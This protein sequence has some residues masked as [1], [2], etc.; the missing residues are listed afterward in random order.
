VNTASETRALHELA[1]MYGVQT[2]YYDMTRTRRWTS[3]EALLVVLRSMGAPVETLRDVPSA[4]RQRQQAQ[5][6]QPLEP[7][8][9][10]W[11]SRAHSIEVR[12]PAAADASFAAHLTL[13]TGEQQSLTWRG[14]DLPVMGA[15]EVE[16]TRYVIKR[17]TLPGRLP[18]GYHRLTLDAPR[19]T[20][21]NPVESLIMVA[22]RRA[23]SFLEGSNGAAW[24]V[25]LPLY[26]LYTQRSWGS[27]ALSDLETLA[28]WVSQ[29]GGSVMATL[30]LLATFPEEPS[31]YSPISR[32]MWNEFYLD[33]SRV[34]ELPECLPAQ[35]TVQSR[36][37]RREI[38][39]L[40]ELPL[41]DY[42]RGM[43]F[44]RRV[45]EQLAQCCFAEA[46]DRL[47]ALM[48]FAKAHPVVEDYASFRATCEKQGVPWQS[49]PD[50]LR[51]GVLKEGDY[52]EEAKRYHLYVQWLAQEQIGAVH[53]NAQEKGVSLYLDL[54]LGVHPDGYD[55]WRYRS[56]FARDVSGGA[57]PDN[58]FVKGQ[59]W[60]F[61]PLHPDGLR[62]QGHR[63]YIDC[64]RHQM[65]HA[66]VL[67]ID[68]AMSFHRLFWVPQGFEA[69][70]GVYVRYP[71]QEFY[72]ILC[73]ESHRHKCC[74]VGENLG[75]VPSYIHR[76]L[77]QHDI[78]GMHV[79]QFALNP[80]ARCGLCTVPAD[81][82]A[83]LNTHDTPTFAGFWTGLDIED[84][85]R[86]GL[87]DNASARR[88]MGCRC[89]TREAVTAFLRD[90]G[91][92]TCLP[93]DPKAVLQ[94]LLAFL[95]S[96]PTKLVLINL[97]DLW[98]ESAPQNV[99]GTTTERPNWQQKC[100]YAFETF[101]RLPEVTEVLR[102]VNRIRKEKGRIR[103]ARKRG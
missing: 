96:N 74:I 24:G 87:L 98:L 54:P 64:L 46:S 9:V 91:F 81:Y 101:S 71:A 43:S 1:R 27:G 48:S 6:Q 50:L 3:V 34:A 35:T 102:Q 10:A 13:E 32:L 67:R 90:A 92:L 38:E 5:W 58:F 88:E 53:Q 78:H 44:K 39:I 65:R 52:N 40:R 22:P 80:Q 86:L 41:V 76:A 25:F 79:M 100:D 56:V 18:W 42:G 33:L 57:P 26:A 85:V 37:F 45:L 47:E 55:V 7:V 82:V 62:Q 99:P 20:P 60:G 93:A 61:P 11:E 29:S 15:A 75:T 69:T 19:A 30:P 8:T 12:L 94:A 36:A 95:S 49:W 84:R 16:G 68:H 21:E 103:H 73:L 97:E 77:R 63:Y 72:A 4:L 28:A 31:P 17:L 59:D 66:G 2:S 23:Y 70:E 51:D 83:S 89:A 14:A